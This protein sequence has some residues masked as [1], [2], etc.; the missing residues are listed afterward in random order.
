MNKII[1]HIA[2]FW[3]F[4]HALLPFGALYILSDI[5]YVLVYKLVGYRLKVVR[6]NLKGSF[7][8]KSEKELRQLERISTIISAIIL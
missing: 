2:Y 4:L 3:L 8:D 5:L 6:S 7:A 1:Y